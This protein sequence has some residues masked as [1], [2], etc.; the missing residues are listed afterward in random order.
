MKLAVSGKGG[1]GKTTIAAALVKSFAR[2]QRL[3]Y[4]I[5]GDPDACLAAAVG[6]PEEVAAG[7]KPVAEMKELIRARSG[8]GPI[9]LLNPRVDDVVENY[10]YHLGNIRFLRMGEVKKGGSECYCR[11]NTFL[12]A[13]VSSLLLDRGEV[14][15]MDMGAGIEHLTRG[16][17]RGVD[18]MLVVVE[19]SRNSINTARHVQK[20][21]EDLGIKKI[22]A[23]GN[24]IRSEKERKFIASNFQDRELLGFV[25]YDESIWESAMEGNSGNVGTKLQSEVDALKER[26]LLEA[27]RPTSPEK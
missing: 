6:I 8:S 16:T 18:L 26:I 23:I 11:E 20:M 15:I 2:T 10:S 7:L 17:A 27:T 5:D 22:R 25:G 19:P 21:A 14:V 12:H 13:L 4:A 1:V 9:Y 24:K 3:V